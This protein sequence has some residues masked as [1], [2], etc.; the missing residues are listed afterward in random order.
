MLIKLVN[1]LARKAVY[2]LDQPNSC[3]RLEAI[4]TYDFPVT[5]FLLY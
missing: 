1:G 5:A 3:T 2:Q 4:Y